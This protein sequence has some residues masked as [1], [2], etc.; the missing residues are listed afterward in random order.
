M[1]LAHGWT[2]VIEQKLQ[3]YTQMHMETYDKSGF[4]NQ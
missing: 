4:L 2:H 3:N 1:L